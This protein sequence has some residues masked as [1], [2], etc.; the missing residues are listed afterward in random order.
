MRILAGR[1][2]RIGMWMLD[3]EQ[4]IGNALLTTFDGELSLEIP[5]FTVRTLPQR[6]NPAN[7]AI[8]HDLPVEVA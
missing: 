4:G 2:E 6:N 5:R 7:W 8:R 1:S 3:Q